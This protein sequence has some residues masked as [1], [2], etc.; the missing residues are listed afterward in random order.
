MCAWTIFQRLELEER[1][2]RVCG[3]SAAATR[4]GIS[5]AL[6]ARICLTKVGARD[7]LTATTATK[8]ENKIAAEAS[9]RA[10]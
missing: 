9:S 3:M 1:C 2:G 7:S 6:Q 4:V 8:I 10:S 5:G